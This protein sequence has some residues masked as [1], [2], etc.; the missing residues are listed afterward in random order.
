M[1]RAL[2][3]LAVLFSA[4]ALAAPIEGA[5]VLDREASVPLFDVSEVPLLGD[6]LKR[7]QGPPPEVR[8]QF[9]ET[10]G[11]LS[12][13]V[14][15]DDKAWTMAVPL[16]GSLYHPPGKLGW[17]VDATHWREADGALRASIDGPVHDV[18]LALRRV[19]EH[20][21]ELEIVLDDGARKGLQVFRAAKG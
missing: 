9:K 5:W 8:V 16:D 7:L 14:Q 17:M 15:H 1:F 6:L 10:E 21:L 3:V 13:T 12:W 19:G 11:Q 18:E 20:T 4:P 2:P